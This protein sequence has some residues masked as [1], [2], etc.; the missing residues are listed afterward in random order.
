[1]AYR[2]KIIF[3]DT[4]ER[5]QK[6]V[7]SELETFYIIIAKD[8]LMKK[9]QFIPLKHEVAYIGYDDYIDEKNVDTNPL[10][11]IAVSTD[12]RKV[13]NNS[14]AIN[15]HKHCIVLKLHTGLALIIFSC[16]LPIAAPETLRQGITNI[17]TA[18]IKTFKCNRALVVLQYNQT[19]D[20]FFVN[21]K[22]FDFIDHC[23]KGSHLIG[24]D[25][26]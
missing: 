4:Q 1:M 17:V 26:G 20:L 18:A 23:D 6:V 15:W 10:Y 3:A 16:Y 11:Q 2:F 8:L 25:H 9:L 5:L 19:T 7:L 13:W 22:Q 12:I 24:V 14:L 21:P